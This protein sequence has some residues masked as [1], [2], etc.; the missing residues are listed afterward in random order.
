MVSFK[1]VRH[2]TLRESLG[3]QFV[4]DPSTTRVGFTITQVNTM[5][6]NILQLDNEFLQ[7]MISINSKPY[8]WLSYMT[9]H[10][11]YLT[12]ELSVV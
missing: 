5:T 11:D 1:D 10:H 6:V 7:H 8:D 2:Q 9:Y 12:A 3:C 4:H